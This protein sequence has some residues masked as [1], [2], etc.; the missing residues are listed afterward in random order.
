ML[1]GLVQRIAELAFPPCC[2]LCRNGGESPVSSFCS[3]CTGMLD[4]ERRTP[5]CPRC[6]ATIAEYEPTRADCMDCRGRSLRVDAVVRVG[7]YAGATGRLL[8]RYKF[9][10][11]LELA[12]I[13]GGYL[14]EVVIC[15][16]W[17][18][19]IEAVVPVP[20]HWRRRLLRRSD[21]PAGV[22]ARA[23]A[24]DMDL[25]LVQMLRRVHLRAHQIGLPYTERFVNVRGAFAVRPG[26]RLHKA[27]LL[28]VDDVRTSGATLDECARVL[29]KA[30]AAEVYGAV[31]ARVSDAQPGSASLAT[32]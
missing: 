11:R 30:G 24:A 18:T 29:R 1:T 7:T 22:L 2:L 31:V 25:P 8:R 3:D 21:Y 9:G 4:Q 32:A 17:N 14:Y 20:T 12:K 19:R 15:T 5:A 26:I 28:L 6:A 27:R 23:V 10:G 13:L 16:P